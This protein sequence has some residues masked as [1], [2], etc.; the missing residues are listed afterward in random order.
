MARREV[1]EDELAEESPD[2][3]SAPIDLSD[4]TVAESSQPA[5]AAPTPKGSDAPKNS[6]VVNAS[7]QQREIP[8]PPIPDHSQPSPTEAL[9]MPAETRR[10]TVVLDVEQG[11]IVVPSFMGKS[12][13][14]AVEEAEQSGLDL[15]AVGSG[16]AKDQS[17]PPGAHVTAGSRVTVKFVR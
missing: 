13:R 12:V 7:L 8:A 2:H 9:P 14:S 1:K 3:L 6:G 5:I 4:T 10:G 11:G 17:P 15:D 16:V